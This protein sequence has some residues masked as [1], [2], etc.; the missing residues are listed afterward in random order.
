MSG[1]ALL[2]VLD[3]LAALRIEIF[4][5]FPYLYDGDATYERSYLT[6]YA[7]SA[8]ALVVGAFA[9]DRLVGAATAAP[10]ADHDA[11]FARPLQARGLDI[12]GIYYF[13]ESVLLPAWRGR[14]IG[15][16]FFER[17][18]ERARALGYAMACFCAVV[19]PDDHPARPPDYSRLDP[20][21]RGHGFTPVP[22]L[23][24][25]FDWREP[26][27]LGESGHPMQYWSK[28]LERRDPI[29]AG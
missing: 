8:D 4:R 5:A 24:G 29:T 16:A 26:G 9:G 3:D 25:H 27:D 22:G 17:R 12:G 20:L 21:W 2:A 13:C 28:W 7:Q 10:M 11:E 19:R 1:A 14:G 15:H 6:V 18:E 23:I